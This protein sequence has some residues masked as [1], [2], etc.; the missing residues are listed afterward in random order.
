M[1]M[2]DWAHVWFRPFRDELS[3][4]R[5]DDSVEQ[6]RKRKYRRKNGE[7]PRVVGCEVPARHTRVQRRSHYFG[8]FEPAVALGRQTHYTMTTAHLE[9]AMR[10]ALPLVSLVGDPGERGCTQQVGGEYSLILR[11]RRRVALPGTP[12]NRQQR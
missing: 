1:A 5:D 6:N 8:R 7:T 11:G 10:K 3:L 4:R 12:V 9:L 2:M